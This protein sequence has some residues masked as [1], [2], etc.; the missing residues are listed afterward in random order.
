METTGMT[1]G[2]LETVALEEPECKDETQSME[3]DQDPEVCP[4][5]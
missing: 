4:Y 3:E 2:G 1:Q 5:I